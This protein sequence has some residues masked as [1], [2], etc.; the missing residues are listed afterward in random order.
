MDT[1]TTAAGLKAVHDKVVGAGTGCQ[2]IGL[3][4]GDVGLGR[5][6][7]GLM[8]G[9]VS[10][11]VLIPVEQREVD[12]PQEVVALALD[13]ERVGHVGAH[14]AQDLVREQARAGG[15][16][17]KVAGL[18]VHALAQSR[19]LLVREE[20]DDGAVDGAV[21]AEGNPSQAL[22]AKRGGHA[23]E[24][25]DLGTC[26]GTGALGVDGLDDRAL[27][28]CGSRKDLELGVG[29]DVGQVDQVHT[30]AGIGLVGAI[31]VHGLPVV[32]ATQ[33]R[34][35]LDTHAAEGIG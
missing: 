10:L 21:L 1:H 29:K 23:G 32:H 4:L 12:D 2:R 28:V 16:H 25:I 33:R 18:D 35:H 22:G 31:G 15:E 20:L 30:V 17:H 24:L 7:K 11:A 5:Q 14:A 3:N 13:L 8:L 6:G 26:P 34:G 9:S 19:H 27:L